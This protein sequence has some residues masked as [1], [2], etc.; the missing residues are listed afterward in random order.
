VS[1]NKVAVLT[2]TSNGSRR[3]LTRTWE[4]CEDG[5]LEIQFGSSIIRL[6]TVNLRLEW[7][8]VEYDPDREGDYVWEVATAYTLSLLSDYILANDLTTDRADY[9]MALSELNPRYDILV[10]TTEPIIGQFF[11]KYGHHDYHNMFIAGNI[12]EMDGNGVRWMFPWTQQS[13]RGLFNR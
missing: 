9:V 5:K 8:H 7:R 2:L 12:Y 11:L 4:I 3:R 13:A 6:D 10:R 1:E